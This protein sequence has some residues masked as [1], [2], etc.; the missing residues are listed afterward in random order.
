MAVWQA[1]FDLLSTA[2]FP[3]DY[4][5]RL[6]AIVASLPS[7]A[8][9]LELWGSEDGN[10]IDVWVDRA[11]PVEARVRFDMRESS[12]DFVIAVVRFASDS[13]T[14][15]RAENGVEIHA[16]LS[17]L[18]AALEGSRAARFVEDPD[19]YFRRLRAGGLEDL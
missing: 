6:S 16:E 9:D 2:T 1:T 5:A 11:R 13:H 10:R 18:V 8:P 4:R 19:R 15:F 12:P 3:A 14:G 17:E 7:W